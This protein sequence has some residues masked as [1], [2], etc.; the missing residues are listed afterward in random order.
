[1][2]VLIFNSFMFSTLHM[3]WCY[4]FFITLYQ[5]ILKIQKSVKMLLSRNICPAHPEYSWGSAAGPIAAAQGW[6][7]PHPGGAVRVSLFS[8]P[9]H[10]SSHPLVEM[11]N[12][13]V[14]CSHSQSKDLKS[15]P[16]T[17]SWTHLR[18][19]WGVVPLLSQLL[20]LPRFLS[21]T[22]TWQNCPPLGRKFRE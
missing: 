16:L 6:V 21:S 7:I 18:G 22:V 3:V 2:L 14:L 4:F 20:V 17:D 15:C 19:Q 10:P 5:T 13:P 12:T 9:L 1:M 11:L 8:T